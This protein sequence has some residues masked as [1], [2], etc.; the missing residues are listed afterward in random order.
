MD[1]MLYKVNIHAPCLDPQPALSLSLHFLSPL[2]SSPP[3][4]HDPP[5]MFKT[6]LFTMAMAGAIVEVANAET[7]SSSTGVVYNC[8]TIEMF[9][10]AYAQSCESASSLSSGSISGH[11]LIP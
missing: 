7:V 11:M 9:E 10:V 6:I 3:D 8:P 5:T 2:A 1:A 4:D